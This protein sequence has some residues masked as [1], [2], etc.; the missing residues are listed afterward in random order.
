MGD[1]S[2]ALCV[3]IFPAGLGIFLVEFLV[4]LIPS[5][6]SQ[7]PFSGRGAGVGEMFLHIDWS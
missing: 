7:R 3:R 2:E 4:G 1:R 6:N 5:L